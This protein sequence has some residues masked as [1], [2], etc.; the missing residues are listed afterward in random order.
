[1]EWMGLMGKAYGPLMWALRDFAG[2]SSC[3]MRSRYSQSFSWPGDNK[4]M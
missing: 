2:A 4:D 3:I 1:M